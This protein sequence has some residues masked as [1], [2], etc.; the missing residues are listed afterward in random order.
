LG[1]K[2]WACDK[3]SDSDMIIYF[4]KDTGQ[5]Y[6]ASHYRFLFKLLKFLNLDIELYNPEP[7]TDNSFIFRV[8]KKRILIDYGD[9]HSI[10]NDWQDS[11]IRF[12]FHYLKKVHGNLS[13]VFPLI[14]ISFY[15]WDQYLSFQKE[16]IYACNAD[17]VLSNQ[18]PGA[19]AME[20]RIKVQQTLRNRYKSEFDNKITDQGIFWKKIN[21]CLI[22]VCVP[23]AR[24]DILDRGQ[25]QYMA[26]GAC[27]IS[28]P[29]DITLPFGSQPQTGVHYLA[30]SPDYSNLIDVIE[31]CKENRDQCRTIGRQA[32]ELFLSTSTPEKIWKWMNQCLFEENYQ[33]WLKK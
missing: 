9:N 5:K 1:E 31:H 6:Y 16:I 19:A 4:P 26:F 25:F 3:E 14:P 8:D 33:S 21:N 30:C 20:R 24:N 27:T 32:K 18:K 13:N 2:L 11:D 29:L 10:A 28:P 7:R 15:N 12:C 17:V 23:G 22:S